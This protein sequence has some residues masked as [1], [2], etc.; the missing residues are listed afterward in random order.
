MWKIYIL[1]FL[2]LIAWIV[3]KAFMIVYFIPALLAASIFWAIFYFPIVWIFGL[4]P[5]WYGNFQGIVENTFN[6]VIA[7][8]ISWPG[9]LIDSFEHYI[10]C[11]KHK[12]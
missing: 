5:G 7:I 3:E 4:Y 10:D 6:D 2:F 11:K 1:K 12:L 9:D 8:V